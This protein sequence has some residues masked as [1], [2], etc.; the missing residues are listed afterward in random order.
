MLSQMLQLL[1]SHKSLLEHSSKIL[2]IIM[3][4][5]LSAPLSLGPSRNILH[6]T[7]TSCPTLSLVSH[8]ITFS[9]DPKSFENSNPWYHPLHPNPTNLSIHFHTFSTKLRSTVWQSPLS[10]DQD[11]W[12]LTA[13]SNANDSNQSLEWWWPSVHGDKKKKKNTNE[14]SWNFNFLSASIYN[15]FG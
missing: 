7:R 4:F 8:V 11:Y 13:G 5:C 2:R 3:L 6:Y 14:T 9:S 1:V 12:L 15:D 10:N